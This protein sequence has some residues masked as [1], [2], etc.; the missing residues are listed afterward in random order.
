[1]N[2]CYLSSLSRIEKN[3]HKMEVCV[4]DV[5]VSLNLPSVVVESDLVPSHQVQHH[6]LPSL[7]LS[8]LAIAHAGHGSTIAVELD[9]QRLVPYWQC[10]DTEHVDTCQKKI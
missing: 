6:Q 8:R 2:V 4:V 7:S 3:S 10:M 5:M 9:T 1:M